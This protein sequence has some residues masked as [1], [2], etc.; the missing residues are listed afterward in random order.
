MCLLLC[1]LPRARRLT[2]RSDRE[3][4]KRLTTTTVTRNC[5]DLKLTFQRF[6]RL[7]QVL[8]LPTGVIDHG[9]AADSGQPDRQ[10]DHA[11]T[12]AETDDETDKIKRTGPLK[13]QIAAGE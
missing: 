7:L 9:L 2:G 8:K 12:D 10:P 3:T 6:S 13:L 11:K 4:G 1:K 5:S